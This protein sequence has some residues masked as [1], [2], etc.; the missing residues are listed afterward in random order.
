[1]VR[2]IVTTAVVSGLAGFLVGSALW[3]VA[4]PVLSDLF[5]AETTPALATSQANSPTEPLTALDEE[6][7]GDSSEAVAQFEGEEVV[8]QI[9]AA[10]GADQRAIAVE[11]R[12][13]AQGEVTGVDFVHEGQGTATVVETETGIVL[14]FTDFEVTDGRAHEVLLVKH[15]NPRSNGDVA[16]SEYVSLGELRDHAGDQEYP[17]PDDI[18]ISD[19]R[20]VV[21]WCDRLSVLFAGASLVPNA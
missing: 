7:I 1:M 5:V 19:Y 6:A 13:V 3:F 10:T 12:V 21:I 15:P 14:R 20:S 8:A 9:E 18:D 11:E 17:V 4:S 2:L 16:S